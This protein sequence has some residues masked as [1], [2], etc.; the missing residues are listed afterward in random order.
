MLLFGH[1]FVVGCNP[2][3][4]LT[5]SD[6]GVVAGASSSLT[7]VDDPIAFE[8]DAFNSFTS[9][10]CESTET[11]GLGGGGCTC[12]PTLTLNVGLTSTLAAG[13]LDGFSTVGG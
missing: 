13:L 1:G 2:A 6:L 11:G 7:T 8:L 12:G 9:W 3:F 10:T 4:G 5:P